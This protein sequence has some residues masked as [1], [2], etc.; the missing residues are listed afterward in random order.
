VFYTDATASY[1]F[2]APGSPELYLT[3]TNLFDRK[4]P[5][6]AA[7][8]APGLLYPTLFTL[9]NIAGRTYTAGVRFRF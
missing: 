8:A 6:V 9:Y 4:P 7:A 3:V 2:D 1:K 5:L